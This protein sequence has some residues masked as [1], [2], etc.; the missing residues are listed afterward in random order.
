D[1]LPISISSD[2]EGSRSGRET[3]KSSSWVRAFS[4]WCT[5]RKPPPPGPVS[6]LSQIHETAA[7]AMHASTAFPPARRT[8]APA[9]AVSGCPAANAP[10]MD[11]AYAAGMSDASLAAVERAP[12]RL[13]LPVARE[14]VFCTG[15][16]TAAAVLLV[17]LAPPGGDLAA[18]EYQRS[19][20]LLHGF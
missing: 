16:A 18:H 6:G 13:R 9:S 15:L 14:A 19:L 4:A 10:L 12:W 3:K 2:G 7:A 17:W 1:A 5:S 11:R 8:S 20:Y